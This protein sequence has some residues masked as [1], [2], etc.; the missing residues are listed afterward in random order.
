MA[1]DRR[2]RSSRDREPRDR[3][4]EMQEE[5][6]RLQAEERGL[7]YLEYRDNSRLAVIRQGLIYIPSG[8]VLGGLFI[9]SLVNLPN[10]IIAFV[11][12]GIFTVP[13]LILAS[14][15]VL[16]LLRREPVTSRGIVDRQWSKGRFMFIGRVRYVLAEVRPVEDGRVD[17]DRKAKGQLFEVEELADSQ[18][19]PGDEIEVVHWPHTNAIVSLERLSQSPDT[20]KQRRDPSSQAWDE[21]ENRSV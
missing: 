18:L 1:S 7:R 11:I 5:A 9:I 4:K 12:L 21:V 8:L 16:D 14:H 15:A 2:R 10:S 19:N 6:L 17:L 13:V 3:R 20:P